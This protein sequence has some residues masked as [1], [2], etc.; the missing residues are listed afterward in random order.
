MTCLAVLRRSIAHAQ[1]RDKAARNV[2][3]LV[4]APEGAPRLYVYLVVSLL[5]G[6]RTE[7]ARP[8]TSTRSTAMSPHPAERSTPVPDTA[9]SAD[10]PHCVSRCK[11]KRRSV[12]A[13][14]L[15]VLRC[16]V[17]THRGA[18]LVELVGVGNGL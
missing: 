16:C 17:Q 18:A 8:L 13:H 14:A 2:A 7:E 9:I 10:P 3:L 1:R 5:S 15:V 11:A 4:T 6:V 12:T